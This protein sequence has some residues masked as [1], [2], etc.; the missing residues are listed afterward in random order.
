MRLGEFASD[1][2]TDC[3]DLYVGSKRGESGADWYV[4][5]EYPCV[6]LGGKAWDVMEGGREGVRVETG[7]M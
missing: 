3:I 5:S 7:L 4:D 1:P 6:E 2:G